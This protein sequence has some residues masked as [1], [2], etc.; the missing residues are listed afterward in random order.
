MKKLTAFMLAT[1]MAFS[2]TAC[3]AEE[4]LS[5]E[6]STVVDIVSDFMAEKG[7]QMQKDYAEATGTDAK[8]LTVKDAAS[9]AMDDFYGKEVSFILVNLEGDVAYDN[10]ANSSIQLAYRP[11]FSGEEKLY[12]SSMLTSEFYSV[13]EN[14][15]DS[16]KTEE[17]LGVHMTNV[18]SSYIMHGGKNIWSETETSQKISKGQIKA[19]NKALEQ[20]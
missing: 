10:G 4:E 17:M 12:D 8:K 5:G 20:Q 14:T 3:G 16:E 15:P 2:M 6:G 9:F 13:F 7:E 19:I 18:Y 1:V 11:S